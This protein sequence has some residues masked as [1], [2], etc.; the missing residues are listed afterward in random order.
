MSCISEVRPTTISVLFQTLRYVKPPESLITQL[1]VYTEEKFEDEADMRER[2]NSLMINGRSSSEM[3]GLLGELGQLAKQFPD[4]YA[5]LMEILKCY[6]SLLN[7]DTDVYGAPSSW[8]CRCT[9]ARAY[10][11]SSKLICSPYC[12]GLP[13]KQYNSM[14]CT[15]RLE[16]PLRLLISG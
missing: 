1:D 12:T 8:S 2:A 4:L 7:L 14:T 9:H 15:S 11:G 3:D 13:R 10:I 6:T 16:E 5:N